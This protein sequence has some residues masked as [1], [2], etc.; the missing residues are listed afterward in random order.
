ML[1]GFVVCCSPLGR[2]SGCFWLQVAIGG[3]LGGRMKATVVDLMR[4][5]GRL[6]RCDVVLD[7]LLRHHE[8]QEK[9]PVG[10]K[11]DWHRHLCEE[12][13]KAKG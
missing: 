5:L 8:S 4:E 13:R 10:C 11:A 6:E 2:D 1:L 9:N 3:E 12:I 7:L